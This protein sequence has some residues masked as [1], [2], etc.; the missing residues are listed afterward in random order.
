MCHLRAAPQGVK[1][2]RLARVLRFGEHVDPSDESDW[3]SQHEWLADK[4]ELF[5]R[6]FRPRVK[7]LNADDLKTRA[8]VW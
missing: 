8:R 1:I 5:E 2:G 3:P 7:R 6:V 4:P